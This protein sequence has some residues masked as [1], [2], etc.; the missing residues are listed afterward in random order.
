MVWNIVK[1]QRANWLSVLNTFGKDTQLVLL[2]EAQ[3]TP[4][5]VRYATSTSNYSAA[6]QVPALIFPQHSSG[7]YDFIHSSYSL[8]LSVA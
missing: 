4:E 7:G 8:L 6:D 5:L 2:Q 3:T 1:Q